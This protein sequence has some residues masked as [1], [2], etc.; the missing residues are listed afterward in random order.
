VIAVVI[1]YGAKVGFGV[2]AAGIAWCMVAT[3]IGR[4]A[5]QAEVRRHRTPSPPTSGDAKP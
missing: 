4:R 5:R 2:A 3:A 1:S